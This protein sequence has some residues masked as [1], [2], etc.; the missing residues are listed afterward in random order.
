MNDIVLLC[1]ASGSGD[2]LRQLRRLPLP[3]VLGVQRQQEIDPPQPLH[4][5]VRGAQVHELRRGR[6]GSL[7]RLQRQLMT[8]FVVDWTDLSAI[9]ISWQ[10]LRFPKLCAFGPAK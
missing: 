7:Q 2:D 1:A 10:H 8:A 9:G 4:H 3:A 5:R 6:T